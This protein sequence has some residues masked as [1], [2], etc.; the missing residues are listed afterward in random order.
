V[1]I[2]RKTWSENQPNLLAAN[3]VFLDESSI[4]LAYTRLYGR[5]KSNLRIN[6]GIKD[7]RFERRSILSTIRLS[8][9]QVPF[10]FDGTLNEE[11]FADYVRFQLAP[12]LKK[13]DIVVLDNCSVHHAKLVRETL[14]E[15]GVT[16]LFLPPYSPD[17]NPIELMWAYVKMML[18]KLKARTFDKLISALNLALLS[19]T[20]ELI[21]AWFRHCGYSIS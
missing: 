14:E 11:L 20:N 5:A 12:T 16:T 13:E 1:K 6:E 18:K 2:K 8:G 19:V 7:V 9:E 10:V 3:L 4:N 17:Y 15:C 21:A